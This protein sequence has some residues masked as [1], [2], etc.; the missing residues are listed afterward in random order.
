LRGAPEYPFGPSH[1][2][3]GSSWKS[4]A[5]QTA[6]PIYQRDTFAANSPKSQVAAEAWSG[7]VQEVPRFLDIGMHL[8]DQCFPTGIF[9]LSA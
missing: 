5:G 1:G 2:V 9:H 8:L 3:S 6:R 4:A 7:S